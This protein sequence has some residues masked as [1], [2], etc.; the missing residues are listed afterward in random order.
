MDNVGIVVES[1]DAAVSLFAELGLDS[2]VEPSLKATGRARHRTARPARRDRY[3]AYAGRPRQDRLSRFS[4]AACGRRSPESPPRP[5]LALRVMSD[6][7]DDTPPGFASTGAQ[8]V[9]EVIQHKDANR[10]CYVRGPE[11]ILIGLSDNS[12]D[13]LTRSGVIRE[14]LS[15]RASQRRRGRVA[16]RGA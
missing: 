7:L 14:H 3:D 6:D 5:R 12:A 8:L 4:H 9:D 11:G 16:P 2:K 1:L 15:R 13:A 10:L